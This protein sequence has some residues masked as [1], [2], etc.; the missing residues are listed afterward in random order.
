M[1]RAGLLGQPLAEEAPHQGERLPFERVADHRAALAV[2]RQIEH[3]PEA[4]ERA[5]ENSRAPGV[6]M[7]AGDPLVG[8]LLPFERE[9]RRLAPPRRRTVP[10]GC[11]V[12]SSA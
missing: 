6:E 1:A 9:A 8:P 5:L 10:L 3:R 12:S 11:G 7:P 2:G 4:A